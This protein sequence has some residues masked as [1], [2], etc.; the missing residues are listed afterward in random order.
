MIEWWS[1]EYIKI[2][3]SNMPNTNSTSLGKCALFEWLDVYYYELQ[4]K[5]RIN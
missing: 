2:L 5:P 1:S 3:N 4:Q